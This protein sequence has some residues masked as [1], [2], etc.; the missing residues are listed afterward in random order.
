MRLPAGDSIK[1][2][3]VTVYGVKPIIRVN[4]QSFKNSGFLIKYF[5][6]KRLIAARENGYI[7]KSL[8]S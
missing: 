4:L 8:K 3:A 6:T 1:C 2:E 5:L 7:L